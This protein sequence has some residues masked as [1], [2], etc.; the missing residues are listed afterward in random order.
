MKSGILFGKAIERQFANERLAFFITSE[1]ISTAFIGPGG[2]GKSTCLLKWID[3]WVNDKRNE[4]D[5]VII[6]QAL[7]FNSFANSEV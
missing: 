4:N 6:I 2:Y 3:K 7:D 5:I 1:Y